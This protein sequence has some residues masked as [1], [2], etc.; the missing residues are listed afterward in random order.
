MGR[1]ETRRC[2]VLVW[3]RNNYELTQFMPEIE[4]S[5]LDGGESDQ[6][7]VHGQ[8]RAGVKEC[9]IIEMISYLITVI[10]FQYHSISNLP[11]RHD[12]SQ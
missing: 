6:E 2:S 1:V 7:R 9:L 12:R 5:C 10:L 8:V 4:K 3:T 11:R